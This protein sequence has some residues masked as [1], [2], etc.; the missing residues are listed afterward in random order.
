VDLKE[1]SELVAGAE[2]T[3][4]RVVKMH[5]GNRT[6]LNNRIEDALNRYLYAETG[7]RPL[8]QAVVR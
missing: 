5:A 6:P 7:K 1:A 3:I 8:V 4:A 2:E